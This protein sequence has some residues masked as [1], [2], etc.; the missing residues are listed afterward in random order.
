M[1]EESFVAGTL[2][3]MGWTLHYRATNVDG[4]RTAVESHPEA[5][6]IATKDYLC[7]GSAFPNSVIYLEPTMG[8]S[9]LNLQELLRQVDKGDS[10]QVIS[11]PLSQIN[12]TFIA[13]LDAGV[14]GSTCAINIAYEKSAQGRETLL[15][16]MNQENP[17]ISQFF[18]VQRINRKISR[19]QF[20]F[21]LSEVSDISYFTELAKNVNDFEEVVVDF[22]KIVVGERFNSGLR[23]REIAARWCV[24]SATSMFIVARADTSSLIKLALL[25]PE[26]SKIS[27]NLKPTILLLSQ[28]ANSVRE[29]K[30]LIER[31][32]G[33]FGGEVGYLPRE[34]RA[35]ERAAA[36]KV[37]FSQIS[38]KSALAQGFVAMAHQ[39]EKRDR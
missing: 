4:L 10:R 27:R 20:G 19:T 35:L 9:K 34:S 17:N 3:E 21:S 1:K 29:R 14:G 24:N 15:L 5:L 26:F 8:L 31:A 33:I 11:I 6:I 22:G 30:T 28:G 2:L 7:E 18:D 25:A 39:R 38:P 12:T 32:S 36:E 23:I 16:D 13:T 37:P